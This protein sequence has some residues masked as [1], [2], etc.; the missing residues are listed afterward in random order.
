MTLSRSC[1]IGVLSKMGENLKGIMHMTLQYFGVVVQNAGGMMPM[2]IIGMM[3]SKKMT[4]SEGVQ[5]V[6]NV[7]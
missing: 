7:C 3:G 5:D 2:G 6:Q 1:G 4:S